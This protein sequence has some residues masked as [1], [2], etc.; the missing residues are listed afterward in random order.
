VPFFP[1]T[2]AEKVGVRHGTRFAHVDYDFGRGGAQVVR[3]LFPALNHVL[4]NPII[5]YELY[6][7][8]E[9][10]DL[11]SGN[12]YRL[13]RLSVRGL[14]PVLDKTFDKQEV[15]NPGLSGLKG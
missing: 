2:V 1:E 4:F 7:A 8:R 12:A 15:L 3:R 14:K 6:A 13:S 5:P 9:S 10:A 11:M